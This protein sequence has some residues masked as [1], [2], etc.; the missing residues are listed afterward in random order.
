MANESNY[1]TRRFSRRT[2]LRGAGLGL[3][4]LAGAALIGCGDDDEAAPSASATRA[5]AATQASS[6]A[7]TTAA[8][9]SAINKGGTLTFGYHE[10][11]GY[12][13]PRSS[14]AGWDNNFLLAN[15]DNYIYIN[16]DGTIDSDL[17]LIPQFEFPDPTTLIF[18]LRSGVSFHDG[19]PF[20][21]EAVKGHIE[22]LQDPDRTPGFG[23]KSL[24]ASISTVEAVDN[25]TAKIHLESP[26]AG[27]I[28]A[29]GVAPG[30][31]M[32]LAQ[33]DKRGEDEILD[34]AL[35]GP[36]QVDDYFAD[37][38]W[39]YVKNENYWGPKEGPPHVDKLIY[40]VIPQSE[41]RAAALEVGDIDAT[42]F[43]ASNET[44][45]RLSQDENIQ[46]R[47]LVAGPT[48]VNLNQNLPPTDNLKVRQAIASAL[49][50]EKILEVTFQGQGSLAHS[51][52]P[53][54]TYGYS[55]YDP[56]PFNVEQAKK[57]LAE[58]GL[59][60]PVKVRMIFGGQ[61]GQNASDVLLVSL[62]QEMLEEVGFKVELENL[63]GAGQLFKE[64]YETGGANL[65]PFSTGTRPDPDGQF[66][67]YATSYAYYNAG[68][69]TLDPAQAQLDDM[70]LAARQNL[71]VADREQA[72][73]DIQKVLMD[74]VYAAIP[75]IT[76]VRWVFAR[77]DV[78]GMDHPELVNTPAGASFRTRYLWKKA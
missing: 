73:I 69:E 41:P 37:D 72:Y 26:N 22:L 29:F 13:S 4:G 31:P 11:R 12:L 51:M 52:L 50:K 24:I 30:T 68:R 44:T 40:R 42:W 64:M 39:T 14:R 47:Q 16:N 8:P 45:L 55:D 21:G 61:P 2:V 70:V 58:S 48:L 57:Y 36:F 78:G 76:R 27:I 10:D 32:S 23:Y 19:T 65:I 62:Y 46:N 49:D 6:A 54:G 28:G 15:G 18:H 60:L 43:T 66:S 5:P 1:W 56:Y 77:K 75:M 3:A 71:D 35:T 53:P 25:N 63:P 38:H 67:L 74:N 33:I 34:P 59:E 20:N 7:T 9:A 17:S